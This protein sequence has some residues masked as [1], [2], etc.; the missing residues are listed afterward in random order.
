M[1]L[2]I[3]KLLCRFFN[4][5]S[6]SE[7]RHFLA[8]RSL[9]IKLFSTDAVRPRFQRVTHQISPASSQLLADSCGSWDIEE[10]IVNGVSFKLV[11]LCPSEAM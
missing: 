11:D 1:P 7:T 10:P 5:D 3:F 2:Q 9:Q 4:R 8:L 6:F